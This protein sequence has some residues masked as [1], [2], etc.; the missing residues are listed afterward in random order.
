MRRLIHEVHPDVV[1][2]D[3]ARHVRQRHHRPCRRCAR[4]SRARRGFT[5]VYQFAPAVTLT[6]TRDGEKMLAQLTFED[7][8]VVLHQNGRDQKAKKQEPAL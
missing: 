6:I 4:R 5:G 3:R 1:H 7:G 2:P 8:A